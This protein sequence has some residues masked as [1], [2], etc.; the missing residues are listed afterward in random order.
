MKLLFHKLLLLF[1]L[2]IFV[3]SCSKNEELLVVNVA[4]EFEIKLLESLSSADNRFELILTTLRNQSCIN[5]EI[6]LTN[7]FTADRIR[8]RIDGTLADSNVG[9]SI[10][11]NHEKIKV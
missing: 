9:I 5:A 7:S 6:S 4:K 10:I 1:L 8:V 3:Q 11:N 2:G